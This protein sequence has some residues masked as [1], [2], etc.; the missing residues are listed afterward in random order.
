MNEACEIENNVIVFRCKKFVLKYISERKMED[1]NM[2]SFASDYIA[3][4]HP[5]IMQRLLETNMENLSGYGTD[6]YCAQAKEKIKQAFQC[7]DGEVFFLVGGTQ[8]NQVIISTML[9]PY[10][11]VIA[12]KTGH[13]SVHEAGA[14]EYSGHK[15]IELEEKDGKLA[16]EDIK[17]CIEDFYSD[18]NHEHMVYPGMVYISFPTEYGTLY[19]KQEL[20]EISN[21]CR[22]YE[23]PLFIDGARLG[24]GIESKE[25]NLRPEEIAELCDVFYIGGTKV[26]ALCGEAVVF[27]HHNTQK[28]FVTQIKQRGALLAKGRLL[29]IQFDTLFTDHL[30][31][32]ISKHAIAMAERLKE[33]FHKKGY[34]FFLESPTNQQFIILENEKM[35]E[36]SKNVEFGFWEKYDDN[37]TVVRFATSWSTDESSIDQLE[38]YL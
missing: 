34:T 9:A 31:F 12:A 11:G 3:G 7:P 13:V 22:N 33:V 29:G 24:Y 32:E 14:I 37:H 10:E 30:Y 5:V 36:L 17:K 18:D 2:I 1:N 21:V 25:N 26:G 6:Q 27:P 28:H 15:V 20:T 19:S 4:A 16:A 35:K 38:E 8:T 23:I